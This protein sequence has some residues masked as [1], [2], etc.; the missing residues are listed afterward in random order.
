M[1]KITL[2]NIMQRNTVLKNVNQGKDDPSNVGPE[3]NYLFK[4]VTSLLEV[5]L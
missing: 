5:H 3:E 2:N 4:R 1:T